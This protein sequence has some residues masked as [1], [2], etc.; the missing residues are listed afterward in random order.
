MVLDFRFQYINQE[1]LI[2]G[3]KTQN[4]IFKGYKDEQNSRHELNSY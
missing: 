4:K 1:N 2:L 3:Y